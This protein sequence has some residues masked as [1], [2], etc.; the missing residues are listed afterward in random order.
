MKLVSPQ[1]QDYCENHTSEVDALY[2]DLREETY[3]ETDLP[4]MLVGRIEGRFLKL[5]VQMSGAR[6]AV[7]VGTFT[8]YSALSIAEGLAADG[9]LLALDVNPTT[10]A[11]AQRY[12]DQAA[13]G[14]KITLKVGDAM[15]ALKAAAAQAEGAEFD[16]AFVDADKVN[17]S[18]YW[19]LLVPMLKPGGLIVVDNVLWSGS[20]LAPDGES[21]HAIVAFNK[22]AAADSRVE[23]VMLSVRDGM[24]IAR[25]Q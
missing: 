10:S 15:A 23:Q 6:R 2:Q 3:A 24:L 9:T 21:A 8:G 17:Y 18:N 16:F 5:L 13:W 4:Q 25:K 14:H 19:D 1:I 22:H 12:F 7:E 11:I 20:V